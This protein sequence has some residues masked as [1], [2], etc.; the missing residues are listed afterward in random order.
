MKLVTFQSG[1]LSPRLGLLEG[2]KVVDLNAGMKQLGLDNSF[3]AGMLEFL[4]RFDE[5]LEKVRKNRD[6]LAEG[7]WTHDLTQIRPCAP[8]PFPRGFR[9]FYAFEQHVKAVRAKLG[10]D[11]IPE[12][13]EIPVFYFSNHNAMK[14]P[15]E[16][17]EFP[18]DCQARDFELEIGAVVCREGR[19]ISASE[20]ESYIGGLLVLNDWTNRDIQ[21]KETKVIG[22]AK[23]KDFATSIGPWLV[24]LDEL[25]HKKIA[26]G[27]YDL[28]MAARVNGRHYSRG[29]LQDCYWSFC[30]MLAFASHGAT[31]YP[32]EILGSGTVGTGCILELGAAET[33]WLQ[34]GDVVELEVEELGVL[35]NTVA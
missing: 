12:W 3:P 35:R 10:L 5:C 8:L 22:P 2:G 9:D 34:R 31:I 4:E 29:N 14:G 33:G 27:R 28:A 32:G 18:P 24:T 21:E 26:P 17:I 6:R 13:Y 30:Q 20:A 7:P 23:S 25:E 11:V 15:D 16:A 19:D 1:E